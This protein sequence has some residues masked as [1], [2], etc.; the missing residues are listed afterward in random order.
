VSRFH[1]FTDEELLTLAGGIEWAL[2]EGG[3]DGHE[4]PIAELAAELRIR[5]LKASFAEEIVP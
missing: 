2:S 4:P 3:M 1:A 5:R